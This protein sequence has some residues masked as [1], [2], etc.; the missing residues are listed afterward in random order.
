MIR[1]LAAFATV[2]FFVFAMAFALPGLA[3]L[4]H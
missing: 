4:I 3:D 2:W 1:D